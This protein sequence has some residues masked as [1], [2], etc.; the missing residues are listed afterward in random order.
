VTAPAS[1]STGAARGT[2]SRGG[3]RGVVTRRYSALLVR[4]A[5]ASSMPACNLAVDLDAWVQLLALHDIDDLADAEIGT[6]RHRLYHVPASPARHTGRR[7]LRIDR[8][9]PW[10]GVFLTCRQRLTALPALP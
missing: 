3:R 8:T 2:S 6:M 5:T 1:S 9:W 4:Q 7:F 10:A